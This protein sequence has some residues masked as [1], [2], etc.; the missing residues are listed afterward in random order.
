MLANPQLQPLHEREARDANP[1]QKLC[2]LVGGGTLLAHIPSRAVPVWDMTHG[3]CGNHFCAQRLG[4][5][6]RRRG[7]N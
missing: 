6:A 5:A 1:A 7:Y 3:P 4:E 2:G